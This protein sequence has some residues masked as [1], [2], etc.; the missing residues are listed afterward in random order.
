MISKIQ[1]IGIRRKESDINLS[2][3]T[4][5]KTKQMFTLFTKVEEHTH[6]I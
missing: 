6:N 4:T 5:K 3:P 2:H 1:I